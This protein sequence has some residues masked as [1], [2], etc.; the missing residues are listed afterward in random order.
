[1]SPETKITCGIILLTVPTIMYGG[2]FLMIYI[3][4]SGILVLAASLIILGIGLIKN[5]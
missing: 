5:H 1:M 4:Y 2:Y 3:L